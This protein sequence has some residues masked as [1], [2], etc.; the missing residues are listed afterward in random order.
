MN[1]TKPAFTITLQPVPGWDSVPPTIRLKWPLS[2][3][4]VRWTPMYASGK[5]NLVTVPTSAALVA[6]NCGATP[7]AVPD[8]QDVAAIRKPAT[9]GGDGQNEAG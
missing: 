1:E 5:I 4:A 6:T 8:R 2:G 3:A 7:A 9:P